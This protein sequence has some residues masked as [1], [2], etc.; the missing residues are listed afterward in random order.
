MAQRDQ[1]LEQAASHAS[2]D[3]PGDLLEAAEELRRIER[4]LARL[5][6]EQ[7]EAVRLRVLDGLRVGE[8]AD[9]MECSESTATS[10][11]RYGLE[12]LRTFVAPGPGAGP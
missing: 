6:E 3:P 9:V 12:K 8:I 4:L 10:R 1:R 7:A 2:T 5:P 11:L